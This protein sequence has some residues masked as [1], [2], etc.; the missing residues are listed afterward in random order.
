MK[1]SIIERYTH[2]WGKIEYDTA[3]HTVVFSFFGTLE[4]PEDLDEL[5]A[6]L[7]T[8][9]QETLEDLGIGAIVSR[10]T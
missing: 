6:D 4:S 5:I 3:M 8:I 2:R 7:Q 9:R 10:E 1:P